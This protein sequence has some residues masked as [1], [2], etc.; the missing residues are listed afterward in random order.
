V[1]IFAVG[2]AL[3]LYLKA[4]HCKLVGNIKSTMGF[5]H[6]VLRLWGAIKVSDPTFAPSFEIRQ[7][8]L[9][10]KALKGGHEKVLTIED[11]KHYVVHQ[12]LYIVM[13]HLADL[14]YLGAPLKSVTGLIGFAFGSP[15]P[16][17]AQ[18]FAEARSFIGKDQVHD[19]I[20][21]LIQSGDVPPAAAAFLEPVVRAWRP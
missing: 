17:W 15:D 8:V 3:E 6:D 13:Q 9:E 2:H 4:I 1:Q 5:G 14:K 20:A 16:M 11:S 12:Q 21:E 10:V 19:L 7:A 18:L